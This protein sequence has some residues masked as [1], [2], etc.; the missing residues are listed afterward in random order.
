MSVSNK[1][2]F[3]VDWSARGAKSLPPMMCPG[4]TGSLCP[5]LVSLSG[6]PGDL[7]P[8]EALSA[9]DL[10]ADETALKE[11]EG[12][13]YGLVDQCRG[14]F[15]LKPPQDGGI[16]VILPPG[17]LPS[18][19]E[20][21][22]GHPPRVEVGGAGSLILREPP[23]FVGQP[24]LFLEP[25]IE[26]CAGIGHEDREVHRKELGLDS[27]AHR[28][29]KDSFVIVVKTEHEGGPNSDTMTVQVMDDL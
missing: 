14:V 4:A 21:F 23:S 5:R 12:E 10:F 25:L 15:P 16:G 29:F 24:P 13:I 20:L 17:P 19:P 27:E 18:L 7:G 1:N 8:P 22:T 6:L 28:P 26:G 9:Q 2:G 3:F 11:V